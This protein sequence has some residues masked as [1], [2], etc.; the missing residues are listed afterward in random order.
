MSQKCDEVPLPRVIVRIA[1]KPTGIY[2]F[3]DS[4]HFIQHPLIRTWYINGMMVDIRLIPREVQMISYEKFYITIE[5]QWQIV[6]SEKS[7]P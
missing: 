5:A 7:I 6:G 1:S 2:I 3:L 4:W